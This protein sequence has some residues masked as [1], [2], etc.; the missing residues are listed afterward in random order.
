MA[1]TSRSCPQLI[2]VKKACQQAPCRPWLKAEPLQ[3]LLCS[4][5]MAFASFARCLWLEKIPGVQGWVTEKEG[6]FFPPACV[7]AKV[8]TLLRGGSWGC[9]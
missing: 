8:L 6:K 5:V 9:V 2:T 7:I 4:R 1:V 3:C